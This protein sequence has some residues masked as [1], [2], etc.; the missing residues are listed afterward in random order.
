MNIETLGAVGDGGTGRGARELGSTD[1]MRLLTEQ[2][3]NQNPLK[4]AS[5]SEF[6]GQLAQFSALEQSQSQSSSLERLAAAL[7]ANTSLQGLAQAATL[8]GKQISFIDSA[9]GTERVGSVEGVKFHNGTIQ[10]DIGD[11][12]VPL[13][14]VIS[15]D[16]VASRPA[17]ENGD[18]AT[19]EEEGAE[20]PQT[21]GGGSGGG[22]NPPVTTEPPLSAVPIDELVNA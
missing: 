22:S 19:E 5:D 1:F 17:D 14:N 15:I 3:K 21:P 6:L 12:L 9:L 8:I 20:D 7:E 18:E 10:L 4:P 16:G 11:E 2:L 13:G